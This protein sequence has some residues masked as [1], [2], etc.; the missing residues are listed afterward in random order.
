MEDFSPLFQPNPDAASQQ[1]LNALV[2]E[3]CSLKQNPFQA[4]SEELV[5]FLRWSGWLGNH[6]IYFLE[7]VIGRKWEQADK[8]RPW[9]KKWLRVHK[10]IMEQAA[11]ILE[12][13]AS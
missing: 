13:P 6:E 9:T 3:L 12:S 7:M 8:D 1:K 10:E 2:S 11:A 4:I 5:N